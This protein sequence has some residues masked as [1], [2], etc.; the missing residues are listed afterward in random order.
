MGRYGNEPVTSHYGRRGALIPAQHLAENTQWHYP[1]AGFDDF[2]RAAAMAMPLPRPH[3]FRCERPLL[4]GRRL[5][6][7][8]LKDMPANP[9]L[10]PSHLMS[11]L[12]CRRGARLSATR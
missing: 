2:P 8:C 10:E 4:R 12:T 5:Q 7:R 1:Q 9:A 3:I 6:R 11:V